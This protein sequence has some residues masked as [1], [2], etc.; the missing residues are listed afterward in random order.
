MATLP[1]FPWQI[2]QCERLVFGLGAKSLSIVRLAQ[3]GGAEY[4]CVA[5]GRLATR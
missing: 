2:G 4:F 3:P 1:D 5:N